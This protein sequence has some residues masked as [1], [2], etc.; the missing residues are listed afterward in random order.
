MRTK[1]FAGVAGAALTAGIG[2]GVA[3]PAQAE[4]PTPTPTSTASAPTSPGLS[5]F[6]DR[7]EG[8]GHGPATSNLSELAK[9]LG[10]P[11]ETVS[12]ALSTVRDQLRSE[13]PT[14]DA[15]R[16]T[17]QEAMA[18]ALAAE[19]NI[20]ENEVSEALSELQTERQ[21]ARVARVADDK[22]LLHRAVTD[23]TLTQA[24]ADAV[25]KALD[26]GVV[27]PRGG[28]HGHR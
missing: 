1:L 18:K 5:P 16:E 25:Q 14:T 12:D 21:T 10:L 27:S 8:R 3:Q 15:A 26:A 13:R 17:R 6:R 24:E 2:L 20:G 11:E 7:P 23:G 19:L 4:T 28:G 9:T 22:V